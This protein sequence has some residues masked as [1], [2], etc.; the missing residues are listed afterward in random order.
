MFGLYNIPALLS[1]TLKYYKLILGKTITEV[2]GEI[3]RAGSRMSNDIAYLQ[4]LSR[5]NKFTMI[6]EIKPTVSN[7]FICDNSTL[8]GDV[9][10]GSFANIG[11]NVSLRA[12]VASIRIG[13]YVTI[14][15]SCTFNTWYSV[16]TGVPQ[17]IN[18]G[19][20]S[21]IEPGCCIS[22]CIVD[23]GVQIGARSVI[24]EG[25]KIGKGSIIAPNSFI[26]P[27]SY[28]PEGQLWAGSPVQFVRAL[29]EE[30]KNM[31]YIESYNNW[32]KA[33]EVKE[34][35][36]LVTEKMK[37]YTAENYFKWRAKYSL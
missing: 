6:D 1:K 12:E 11:H 9:Q 29:S 37:E 28:I 20:N 5:H 32:E 24:G 13:S 21:I 25:V 4:I 23:E 3:E 18:I 14:G 7:A 16:P 2:G 34:D 22:S 35:D 15:D 31:V 8:C 30:E 17:S 10:V 33:S 19:N 36:I 27:G 26:S